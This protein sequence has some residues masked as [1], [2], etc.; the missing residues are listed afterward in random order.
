VLVAAVMEVF[1]VAETTGAVLEPIPARGTPALIADQLR[2]R[3]VEGTFAPGTQMIEAQLC[4]QLRVSRGP[5]REAL[6]R[7]VQEGLLISIPNRG[8]FV[9]DLGRDDVAEIYQARQA[10][11]RF[12]AIGLSQ[13]GS[14]GDF[15]ELTAAIKRMEGASKAGNVQDL[16]ASDVGFHEALV[17]SSGNRRLSR[18]FGTLLAET[19]ICISALG[20]KYADLVDLVD[21]H[22]ELLEVIRSGDEAAVI[23]AV[24]DHLSSALELFAGERHE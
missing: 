15:A 4:G 5:V 3:I 23:K 20:R 16:A 11:E 12:A 10:I 18:M 1:W 2:R 13:G 21:E 8:V 22:K 9:V 24:D 14:T 19:Q 7:L 17:A 6:Q